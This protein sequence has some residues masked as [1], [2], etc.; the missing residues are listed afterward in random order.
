[1][2]VW[3]KKLERQIFRQHFLNFFS[4]FDFKLNLRPKISSASVVSHLLLQAQAARF[5][6]EPLDSLAIRS[7]LASVIGKRGCRQ[8]FFIMTKVDCD[9]QVSWKLSLFWFQPSTNRSSTSSLLQ[10][11]C[12]TLYSITARSHTAS[13]V[14]KMKYDSKTLKTEY[15]WFTFTEAL[16][17]LSNL[18]LLATL[19]YC[20][21]LNRIQLG[22]ISIAQQW[23]SGDSHLLTHWARRHPGQLD[24][25]TRLIARISLLAQAAARSQNSQQAATN[26]SGGGAASVTS[27]A[28]IDQLMYISASMGL[29]LVGQL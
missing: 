11:L 15:V 14:P 2:M 23:I 27:V 13:R 21:S 1:M 24:V 9:C 26:P 5:F 3:E 29:G 18:S 16:I 19:T 22:L 12:S 25:D 4:K 28:S 17:S 6:K 7:I 10:P 20:F 8:S